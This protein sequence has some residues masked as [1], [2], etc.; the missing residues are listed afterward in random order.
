MGTL[1]PD[2]VCWT[3]ARDGRGKGW[4]SGT[5]EEDRSVCEM[6][7]AERAEGEGVRARARP[8]LA[9]PEGGM[10]PAGMEGGDTRDE[11]RA[12]CQENRISGQEE[13]I[14]RERVCV[15]LCV[16]VCVCV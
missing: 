11:P 2:I 9:K 5:R 12:D 1:W 6:R 4:D 13:W 7:A 3:A 8:L 14:K 10:R 16:C 15:C